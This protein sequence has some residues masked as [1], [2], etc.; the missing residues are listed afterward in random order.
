VRR[1]DLEEALQSIPTH[2][3]P[4]PSLEQVP[5]PADVASR[6][7]FAAHGQGD[8]EGRRVLDLGSGT[9]VL[10]VGAA[11]MGAREAVGVET[12]ADAVDRAR[13]AAADLGVDV[14][15]QVADV[16]DW[17][18]T[19]D[20]VVQNPPFGAQDRGADRPF[21]ETAIAAAPV[22]YTFH[23]AETRDWVEGFVAEIGAEV[24]DAWGVEYPVPRLFEHHEE[25]ERR[26]PVVLLRLE[27]DP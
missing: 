9:G 25:A 18:G 21:L 7:L 20:T 15:F 11:L 14:D 10:A 19:A 26:V 23:L 17:T 2:P 27:R 13:E 8:I 6:L 5:T 3:D 24:T 4:D 22:V 16:Q 12:D 1:R